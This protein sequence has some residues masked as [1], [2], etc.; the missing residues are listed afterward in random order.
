[1]EL[2]RE[3]LN[4][5]AVNA[6]P[7]AGEYEFTV[8]SAEDKKS[9]AGNDMTALRLTVLDSRGKKKISKNYLGKWENGLKM[10]KGFRDSVGLDPFGS[11]HPSELVGLTGRAKFKQG[12]FNNEPCFTVDY[13]VPALPGTVRATP[14]SEEDVP[15]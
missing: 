11:Y 3:E 9:N 12:T 15:F 14:V 2:T 7:P 4:E 1:M 8:L 5:E 13:Y 6:L 10:I